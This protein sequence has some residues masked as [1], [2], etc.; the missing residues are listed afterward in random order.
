MNDFSNALPEDDQ[1]STPETNAAPPEDEGFV[2]HYL[3]TPNGEPIRKIVP[4]YPG[5]PS[6]KL[7]TPKLFKPR[8]QSYP[9]LRKFATRPVLTE[10]LA[11]FT[12]VMGEPLASALN[13]QGLIRRIGKNFADIPSELLPLDFDGAEVRKSIS[14]GATLEDVGRCILARLAAVR[15]EFTECEYIVV[16][17]ARTGMLDATHERVR[18][19]RP[20]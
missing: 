14:A 12:L 4:H 6:N 17:T 19:R 3:E 1:T 10:G 18:M 20:P 15:P 2:V 5:S 13:T 9:S 7:A 11:T 16:A 8:A